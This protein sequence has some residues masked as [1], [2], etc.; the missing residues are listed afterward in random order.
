MVLYPEQ[1]RLSNLQNCWNWYDTRSGR[2]QR[3]AD[4]KLCEKKVG[5]MLLIEENFRKG[6]QCDQLSEISTSIFV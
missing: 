5:L 3:E 2:A 4:S 1:D 6:H